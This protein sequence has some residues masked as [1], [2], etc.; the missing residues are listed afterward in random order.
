[1][2]IRREYLSQP[3]GRG[4]GGRN[5]FNIPLDLIFKVLGAIWDKIKPEPKPWCYKRFDPDEKDVRDCENCEYVI[6]C[7]K[8]SK[9]Q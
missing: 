4:E 3:G 5:K 7:F 2:K 8:K 1:M 6:K 9:K